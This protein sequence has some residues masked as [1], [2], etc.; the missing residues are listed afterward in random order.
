M[1]LHR[2]YNI[3]KH[4]VVPPHGKKS[5][6]VTEA[7]IYFK[8]ECIKYN[9]CRFIYPLRNAIYKFPQMIQTTKK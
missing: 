9:I 5:E 1:P 2:T 6:K 8:Y 7:V 3:H 4:C